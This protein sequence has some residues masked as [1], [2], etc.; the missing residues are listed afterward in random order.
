MSKPGWHK[1]A[2]E[3]KQNYHKYPKDLNDTS[4]YISVQWESEQIKSQFW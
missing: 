2:S 1:N 4:V 3:S